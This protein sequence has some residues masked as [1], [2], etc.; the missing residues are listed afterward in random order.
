VDKKK[1]IAKQLAYPTN[2]HLIFFYLFG[3]G[4]ARLGRSDFIL[5]QQILKELTKAYNQHILAGLCFEL[6]KRL[7]SPPS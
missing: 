2:S 7:L 3:S 5:S 6:E 4:Y 1:V